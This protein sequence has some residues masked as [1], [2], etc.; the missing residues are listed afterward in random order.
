MRSY[1][2]QPVSEHKLTNPAEVQDAI[3]VL[4][5]VKAP[6]QDGILHRALKFLP[7]GGISLLVVLFNAVRPGSMEASTRLLDVETRERHGTTHILS[8]PKVY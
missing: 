3:S 2:F 6:G 5:A 4:K 8:A 7:L 1:S